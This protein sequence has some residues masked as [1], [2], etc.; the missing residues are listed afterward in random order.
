MDIFTKEQ[1]NDIIKER[2]EGLE[3]LQPYTN[4]VLNQ[5]NKL[6]WYNYIKHCYLHRSAITNSRDWSKEDMMSIARSLDT[7][8]QKVLSIMPSM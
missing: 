5:Y 8:R 7:L 6:G 2:I 3:H 1:L 4:Q